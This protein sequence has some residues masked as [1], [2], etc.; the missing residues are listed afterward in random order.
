LSP[1]LRLFRVVNLPTVPGDAL[2]GAAAVV[3]G[4]VGCDTTAVGVRAVSVVAACL[5]SVFLYMFGL[6]DNDLVGASGDGSG[7][8]IPAG[9][10]SPRAARLARGFC[11]FA[12]MI[13]GAAANL[14]PCWWIAAFSL[15]VAVVLYNRTKRCLTMGLC[16]GLDVVCGGAALAVGAWRGVPVSAH[17]AIACAA[18]AW[19]LYVAGVTKFSEG[20]DADPARRRL[21]GRLIG[22]LVYLQLGALL[23]FYVAAPTPVLRNL[24]LA[25]AGQLVLL[26][27]FGRTW[28]KV[29]AS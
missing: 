7:R 20:E 10:I 16:R 8:P 9:E 1:W 2:V 21:V 27:L 15:A 17:A 18:V 5:A 12:A 19:T 4:S 13:V 26:R 25:G 24:L 3:W 22:A 14:P 23:Y 6:A 29:S 11:L 28:P